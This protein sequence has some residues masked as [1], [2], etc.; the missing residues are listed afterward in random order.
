MIKHLKAALLSLTA[1]GLAACS[2]GSDTASLGSASDAALQP[3][4]AGAE[5]SRSL[6]PGQPGLYE[7]AFN[8]PDPAAL[9]PQ[10]KKAAQAGLDFAAD[11]F[12]VIFENKPEAAALAPYL[13]QGSDG[14]ADLLRATDNEPLVRH[15]YFRRVSAN[16]ASAYGLELG[17]RVFFKD[18]NFAVL[19]LP[20]VEDVAEL[21]AAMLRL[22]RENRG[23]VREVCYNMFVQTVGAV[24]PQGRRLSQEDFRRIFGPRQPSGRGLFKQVSAP[25][26]DPLHLNRAGTQ[27]GSWANWRCGAFDTF[28]DEDS[29]ELAGGWVNMTGDGSV[30][31]GLI[32]TGCRMTHEDLVGNVITPY[33]TAPFNAPGVLT[34]VINKDNDP[35]D[36]YGHGTYCAGIIGAVANNGK[37]LAGMCH[38]VEILPIKVIAANG[39]GT[40]AQVAE[41]M[42][43]ADALGAEILSI[44]LGGP[45][46]DRTSQ[47]ATQQCDADGVLVIVA[48]GNWNTS[49]P[50]YPG[51]YQDSFCV[52]GTTLVNASGNQDFSPTIDTN[53]DMTPDALPVAS[54]F[55]ARVGFSNYGPWVDIAA[56]A[57]EMQS[58][59]AGA[60]DGYAGGGA[61]TS[62]A[63]PS[64][65]GCAALLWEYIGAEASADQVRGLL[66]GTQTPLATNGN[67]ANP[68]G[69]IDDS[70]NGT[71]GCV[72]L[73]AA[74]DL[75]DAGQGSAPVISWDN[76]VDGESVSGMQEIRV[77]VSGG[78]GNVIRVDLE[79][80]TRILATV[81][82]ASSGFYR[83]NW[84]TSF[85]FNQPL[86]LTAKVYDDQG[87]MVR[88][89]ITVLPDNAHLVPAWSE[90][91]TE[92]ANDTIPAGWFSF[93]G[94][95]I[96]GNTS[97]G[98]TDALGSAAVPC[99]HSA[100]TSDDNASMSN[101]WLF[102]PILDLR[103]RSTA[104]LSFDLRYTG[105]EVWFL[106]T[107]DDS[108]YFYEYWN[109][110][111]MHEWESKSYDLTP[112][113]GHEVRLLW[114]LTGGAG[115]GI[116]IDDVS[117]DTASGTP[118]SIEITSPAAGAAV[119]GIVPVSVT[120]SDDTVQLRV[121][122]EPPTLGPLFYDQLP[123]N[124][125]ENPTKTYSFYWDSRWV[126]KGGCQ[127]IVTARDD[128]DN[129]GQADDLAAQDSVALTASNI[130]RDPAYLEGFESMLEI[131]GVL[132]GGIEPD[133]DWFTWDSGSSIWRLTQASPQY[134]NNCLRF[135]P[136][137][138]GNYGDN[139]F[140][141]LFSPVHD[142]SD[143][144]R[145]YLRLW[146]KLDLEGDGSSGNDFAKIQMMRYLG[147]EE[148]VTTLAEY[149]KDSSPAG[150]WIEQAFDLGKFKA[151]PF[152]L[153]FLFSSDN[154]GQAGSGWFIDSYE[155]LDADPGISGLQPGRA[156]RKS[157]VTILGEN[158]GILQGSS[159]VSF[160]KAGGGRVDAE[161]LSWGTAAVLVKV[162][163]DAV[164]G[165]IIVKVLGFESNGSNFQVIKPA[166]VLGGI[167][168]L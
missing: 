38:D 49:A 133:G 29:T 85:E 87:H 99:M 44:S 125:P 144:V 134:G 73:K 58:T 136:E 37:G 153:N 9:M 127:L 105:G 8:T 115:N 142:C 79:T 69:F 6:L 93:D 162:P 81:E 1:L 164:T 128:E 119:N 59:T 40:D 92:V 56:P 135:G 157:E 83:F 90:D 50:S 163:D 16:L 148:T 36:D 112:L 130:S 151:A 27:G 45:Y 53:E 158:F 150:Q 66:Q 168:Q 161:V 113:C 117:V 11:E 126:Y 154:N 89:T 141:Q 102:S 78:S 39:W 42:L 34:D 76:P 32:D 106:Y 149:R 28:N 7:G 143:T 57:V 95:Q 94:N 77:A 131:G 26:N 55:D 96:A 30:L 86:P 145:P 14:R 91:F 121:E 165:T 46:A 116:W 24:D 139:E 80:P 3:A 15:D 61:G 146:Q 43:L 12:V 51:Y 100:G 70:S 155:I 47:L 82:E 52:G 108:T 4:P 13:G 72:N 71:V 84:D 104:S 97:W 110:G 147:L 74:M 166:P 123:D 122:A 22:L 35:A 103:G 17:S 137:G 18:V 63:C 67:T 138:S 5:L 101:N 167:S 160:A 75:Y 132:G 21:D 33:S 64:V 23:L 118:P 10:P 20:A 152:R 41:G 25:P 109:A 2:G 156:P 98:A 120:I 65:A 140:D 60:D 124:D 88:S 62:F 54:R 114:T 159:S 111:G 129:D 68:R 107:I 19:R 48:A 31:V